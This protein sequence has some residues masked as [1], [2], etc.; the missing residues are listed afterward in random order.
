M[1]IK[2]ADAIIDEINATV[3]SWNNYA[4]R[5]QLNLELKDAIADTLINI[6]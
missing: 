3:S 2:K 1:H 6:T 4:E 5:V